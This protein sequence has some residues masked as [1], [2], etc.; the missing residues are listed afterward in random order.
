MYE[1]HTGAIELIQM[2]AIKT[3]SKIDEIKV[4]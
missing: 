2:C 3:E 4:G 1:I